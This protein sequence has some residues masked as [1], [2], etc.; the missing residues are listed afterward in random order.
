MRVTAV[1]VGD[2]KEMPDS[3][4]P[5]QLP[6]LSR[7]CF[8]SLPALFFPQPLQNPCCGACVLWAEHGS[9]RKMKEWLAE[10]YPRGTAALLPCWARVS[11]GLVVPLFPT[12]SGI[13]Y[14]L[15]GIG[16][17]GKKHYSR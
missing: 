14:L 6:S 5:P 8:W 13:Y 16:R 17:I 4:T 9:C 2:T 15:A 3:A 11:P 7:S 1:V 12:L 10:Q